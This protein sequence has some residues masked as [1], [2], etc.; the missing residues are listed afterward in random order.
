M[1]TS[2]EGGTGKTRII[3]AMVAI[4]SLLNRQHE[5]MLMAPTGCAADNIYVSHFSWYV[6]WEE[7][8]QKTQ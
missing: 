4:M 2:G 1:H 8:E 6:N 5:I 7:T 3:K